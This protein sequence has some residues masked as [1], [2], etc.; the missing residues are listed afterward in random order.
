ML[1]SIRDA[2]AFSALE[3]AEVIVGDFD[4]TETLAHALED[5]ERA[6]LLTN[7]SERAEGQQANFV[8]VA[9]R[10]GVKHIVKLSQWAAALDSPVRFLRYHAAIERK[11]RESA[12]SHTFLRP[13]LFMQGLLA[14]RET[15]MEQ[16]RFF[17]AVGDARISA[18]DVRDV[19]SAAAAALVEKGHQEQIYNLTGPQ[20]R[21]TGRWPRS[22]PALSAAGLISLIFHPTRCGRRLLRSACQFGRPMV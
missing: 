2:G 16:G 1:R 21:R 14:F 10:A 18:G 15:I 4:D 7:S 5:V 13:N 8:D 3:G 9:R 20:A 19:A 12:M 17:A 6:F 22:F 11:I